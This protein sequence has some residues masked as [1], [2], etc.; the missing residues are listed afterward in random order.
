LRDKEDGDAREWRKLYRDLLAIRREHITP[1]LD[2][3]KTETAVALGKAGAMGSWRLGR[4]RQL[5]LYCNLSDEAVDIPKPPAEA[6]LLYPAEA[7]AT[8]AWRT[9]KLP[10]NCTIATVTTIAAGS[11]ESAA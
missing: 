9:G 4:G 1:W 10:P 3:A 7:M 2:T 11:P 8:P 6:M 5:T